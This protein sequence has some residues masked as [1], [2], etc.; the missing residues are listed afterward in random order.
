MD[1]LNLHHISAK[2][3]AGGLPQGAH[4]SSSIRFGN[5]QTCNGC[6][7]PVLRS[8]LQVTVEFTHGPALQFHVDCFAV[9]RVATRRLWLSA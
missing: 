9:W 5:G 7:E 1:F 8:N 6:D 2:I 3:A 4:E